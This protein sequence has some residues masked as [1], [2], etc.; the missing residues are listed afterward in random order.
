MPDRAEI[1]DGDLVRL[2]IAG[3][4]VAFR[5]LVERHQPMVRARAGQLCHDRH[6]L[7]DVVQEAF[8]Q[9]YVGL[10]RL[11]D[12]DRFAAWLGGIVFNICRA[13]RRR[14][15][16]EL[17]SDWPEPLHPA[18]ADGLP[19]ADDLDRADALREA[20][21]GLPAGQQRAVALFYY[22]GLPAGQIAGTAGAAKASLH[23]ARRR[24]RDYLAAH[25][26]D[27]IPAGPRS[28]TLPAA[29]DTHMAAVRIAHAV[30]RPS[31]RRT[32]HVL[33]VLAD[34]AGHRALPLWL[35]DPG[36]RSL[37][38]IVDRPDAAADELSPEERT[39]PETTTARLLAAASAT[40]TGVD[41][42]ELGP[43]VTAARI[44]ISGP[45]GVQQV[46]ARLAEGLALAAASGAPVRMA[47]AL[48][49][50][51]AVPVAGEDLLGQF[52]ERESA[53]AG[54]AAAGRAVGGP[55][56]RLRYQPRNLALTAGLEGWSLGGTFLREASGSRWRDFS[57]AAQDRSAVLW[58][59]VPDP[60]GRAIL[61][62]DIFADD[63]R[64]HPVTFRGEL[65]TS[66]VTGHAGLF[67]RIVT[68][69]ARWPPARTLA[70]AV[71]RRSQPG[72][73][74]GGEPGRV[75]GTHL[76]A[77]TGSQD[78]T[79]RQLA[80]DVTE[81]AAIIGFGIFLAGR[82]RVELRNA[83]FLPRAPG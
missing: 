57:C 81:D 80:A 23:K 14:A 46:T 6:E 11:R 47:D 17:V 31:R 83:E 45:A 68:E 2:A 48:L 51:L 7:D 18:S 35:N 73:E 24:L 49:G 22:A 39:P 65:R 76:I 30:P 44:G 28:G 26:P 58:S 1:G 52:L 40:V 21:A 16:V 74:S 75:P 36:G 9:A 59:A 8:L 38:R 32:S 67:L 61:S 55:Y 10:G 60:Y 29:K 5:L 15:P 77:V 19:S 3:D 33:V 63:Y 71:G 64:G 27:L 25:R 79:T 70:P 12:P 42:D 43:D 78:W 62:Q 41:I 82:G 13:R 53:P 66:D 34:D 4:Q 54:P 56:R 37:W 20:I 72:G 69:A 50:R